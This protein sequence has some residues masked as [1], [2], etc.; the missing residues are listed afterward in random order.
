V[1]KTAQDAKEKTVEVAANVYN[2][3]LTGVEKVTEYA[4]GIKDAAV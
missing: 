1:I 2:G 4:V 3:V